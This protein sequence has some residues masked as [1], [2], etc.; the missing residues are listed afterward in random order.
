MTH[1]QAGLV[2]RGDTLSPTDAHYSMLT[3][4]TAPAPRSQKFN[5]NAFRLQHTL[6][7]LR[8]WVEDGWLD[9]YEN[10]PA[11]GAAVSTSARDQR[12]VR[13]G[14]YADMGAKLRLSMREGLPSDTRDAL[15]GFRVLREVP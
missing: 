11:D 2:P 10:A 7:N 13:G 6:G 9:N 12:V 4:L 5:D 8:E 3:T 15:T 14:S 1:R